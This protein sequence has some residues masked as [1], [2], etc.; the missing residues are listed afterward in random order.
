[1]FKVDT[2]AGILSVFGKLIARLEALLKKENA[3]EENLFDEKTQIE[4]DIIACRAEQKAA[5]LA[6]ARLKAITGQ[7][8]VPEDGRKE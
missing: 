2:V 3:R 5:F 1:M 7:E 8:E 4:Q 6:I